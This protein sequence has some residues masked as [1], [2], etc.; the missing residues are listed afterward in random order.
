MEQHVRFLLLIRLFT[1][2]VWESHQTLFKVVFIRICHFSV[3]Q[4]KLSC[5]SSNN[6]CSCN[7]RHMINWL[8]PTYIFSQQN[9]VDYFLSTITFL[10]TSNINSHVYFYSYSYS[11]SLHSLIW[12]FP[13]IL[14]FPFSAS[15][16][17]T[18]PHW[19][20]GYCWM[21]RKNRNECAG[22]CDEN[23]IPYT[24][25]LSNRCTHGHS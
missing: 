7:L 13:Q 19:W 23:H 11:Y 17:N 12:F 25:S 6:N 15:Y 16:G 22:K 24:P 3:I 9:F 4:L 21:P 18:D 1:M 20:E 10:Y 2:T 5:D 8:P 14:L